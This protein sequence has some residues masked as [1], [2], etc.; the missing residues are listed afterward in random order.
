[1][2]GAVYEGDELGR[3]ATRNTNGEPRK[4][5]PALAH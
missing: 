5:R 2:D 4:G 3:I 1:M